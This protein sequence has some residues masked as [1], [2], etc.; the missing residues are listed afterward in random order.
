MPIVPM[1]SPSSS[2]RRA[3]CSIDDLTV[4]EIRALLDAARAY[5]QG[6]LP[7]RRVPF[8]VGL[9]FLAPSLRTRAGYATAAVRLG[10]VPVEVE[11]LRAAPGTS[12]AETFGDTL[13][14]LS[15]MVDVTVVR[16]PFAVE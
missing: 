2:E 1:A 5:A 6:T 13:R 15:G 4:E 11:Q 10:G 9:L 14:T 16:T 7:S 3:I 12:A 8:S